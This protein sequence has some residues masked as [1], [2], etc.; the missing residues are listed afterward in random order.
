VKGKKTDLSAAE[1]AI[2]RTLNVV[3]DWWSMLIVRDAMAGSQRFGEFQSNLGLAKNIL[4]ARLKKLVDDGI[5]V[6]EPDEVT[7][8]F[9]RYVLT[10]RGRQLSV[11]LVALWQWGEECCFADGELAWDLID[12]TRGHTLQKL[13]LRSTSGRVIDP[14]SFE[15]GRKPRVSPPAS[16]KSSRRHQ[17]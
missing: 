15:L 9:N 13:Q 11:V 7:P 12:Q 2:S 5:F 17:K 14:E 3:G 6:Q 8:S 4:S 1:C 10:S 16:G